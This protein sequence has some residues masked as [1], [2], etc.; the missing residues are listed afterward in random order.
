MWLQYLLITPHA[1]LG[2]VSFW[3]WW[4]KTPEARRD[5]GYVAVYLLVFYLVMRFAFHAFET[6]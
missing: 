6:K 3:L 1:L 2:F 4:P 5:F